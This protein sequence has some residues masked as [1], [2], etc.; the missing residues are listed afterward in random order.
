MRSRIRRH[1]SGFM[2]EAEGQSL[3]PFA[4]VSYQPSKARYEDFKAVGYRLFSVCVYA[5]DRGINPFS[6]LRPFRPGFWR[7]EDDFD[8]SAADEDFRLI[9][10]QSRP[11]EVFLLPRI[12]LEPP[13]WWENAHPEAWCLDACGKPM[14]C[15]FSSNVW[16]DAC[17]YALRRFQDWLCESGWDKYVIGWHLAAGSTEEFIR[18]HI[19]PGQYIDYSEPSR[20]AFRA[21]ARKEYRDIDALNAAWHTAFTSFDAV[22]PPSPAQREYAQ[23]GALRDPQ[24]ERREIDFSRFY[25]REVTDFIR[26][27]VRKAKAVTGGSRII[28]VFYGNICLSAPETAHADTIRL[29]RDDQIDFLAAPFSYSDNRALGGHWGFQSTLESACLHG[30]P[31]FVEADIRTSLSRPISECM[32]DSN[33]L[34]NHAYD[35]AVWLG[36]QD[37]AGS[38]SQMTR[39][40]AE[41]LTRHASAW[42]F[43]MWG[44][45]YKTDEYMAFHRKA[46]ALYAESVYDVRPSAPIAVF[47]DE[48]ALHYFG[49]NAANATVALLG[50]QFCKLGTCGAAYHS[51]LLDDLPEVDPDRYRLAVLLFPVTFSD[52][53]IKA[54]DKWKTGGRTVMSVLLPG[55]DGAGIKSATGFDASVFPDRPTPV[56]CQWKDTVFPDKPLLMPQVSVSPEHG[57]IVLAALDN[58]MPG[59]IMRRYGNHQIIWSVAPEVPGSFFREMLVLSGGHVWAYTD[60]CIAADDRF[61]CIHAASAGVKRLYLPGKG[62]LSDAFT[63]RMQPGNETYVDFEM[64]FGETRMFRYLH[65]EA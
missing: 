14:H 39:A 51:Y 45:W 61:V 5:G 17:E 65:N 44:G 27:L 23:S 41:I 48:N 59:I 13:S 55:Y 46:L 36:P 22:E 52:T 25:S 38:L 58:G 18:P 6:G 16:L 56:R 42:W 10:G 24:T 35:G 2:I 57:D 54:L 7:G 47:V 32:P 37:T 1:N 50:R 60:D 28:G 9:V 64:G 53:V 63:G 8:F 43:D 4:Y 15:S 49:G 29:L 19:Y 33:P 21:F 30:K 11:G 34:G 3:L 20:E 62:T 26:A 31:F 12:N 40:F